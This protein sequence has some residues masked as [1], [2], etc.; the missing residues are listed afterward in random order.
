MG[1]KG[2]ILIL[3]IAL[4]IPIAYRRFVDDT[5]TKK[6]VSYDQRLK[7]VDL[8]IRNVANK[9]EALKDSAIENLPTREKVQEEVSSKLELAQ[10]YGQQA[11]KVSKIWFEQNVVKK[12]KELQEPATQKTDEQTN[13]ATKVKTPTT[14]TT[15]APSKTGAPKQRT[16]KCKEGDKDIRLWSTKELVK[17]D[18][19]TSDKVYL[20]FLGKVYDVSMNKQHYGRGGDY[21][22]FAGRDASRAFVTGNFTHDL[23]DK[24]DDL[25]DNLLGQINTWISF[26]RT[27]Y[28]NLGRVEGNFYNSDGCPT[29][30]LKFIE[31]RLAKI[32]ADKQAAAQQQD[33][34]P[35]CNS[36]FNSDTKKA[37]VWCTNKSGGVE[38]EW[39]GVPRLYDGGCVCV[40]DSKQ[41]L[42]NELYKVYPGCDPKS[43]ECLLKQ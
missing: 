20:A 7:D 31:K 28:P 37:R 41:D 35:E 19:K 8:A 23:T 21:N 6:I 26:Y 14:S 16:C 4:S 22:V 33:E 34:L 2:T 43:S 39:A 30:A 11:F 42:D 38:R 27:S 24:L 36:E 17:F 5:M 29:E 25:E 40:D 13:K 32:E 1:F 15:T 12:L 10:Q 3:L 9:M 18:G